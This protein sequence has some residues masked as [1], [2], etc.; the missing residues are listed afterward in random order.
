MPVDPGLGERLAR[1]VSD[2]YSA[3]EL[4]ILRRIARALRADADAPDWAVRKA[5]QLDMLRRMVS[6]DLA[7]LD[8]AAQAMVAQVVGEAYTLGT[9]GAIGDIDDLDLEARLPPARAAAVERIAEATFEKLPAVRGA[10]MRESVDVYLEVVQEA[11]ATVVLGADTR[12]GAAQSAL[13]GLTKRGVASFRDKSGRRWEAASYVEMAV[14]TGTG[15]AAIQGHVDTLSENG[16]DLVFVSDSPRE[17][18]ACRPW[19]GKVLSTSGAVAGTIEVESVTDGRPRS[20]RVAGS[21]DQAR[22]RGLFHPNCRHS[23]SAY[24]PG[25]TRVPTGTRDTQERVEQEQHQR[26][27]ERGVRDWKRRA[28]ASV[29]P[30]AEARANAKVREWQARL[31][32]HVAATDLNRKRSREQIGKAR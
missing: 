18:E 14:R 22:S 31:R 2:L 10:L 5:G 19:E 30:A 26:Y 23:V 24:L 16:L 21:L 20:V 12:L 32:E 28:A 9:A 3:A 1:R 27:L 8:A 11:S 17:C 25:A 13:D 7:G 4:S 15:H 29:D 6:R